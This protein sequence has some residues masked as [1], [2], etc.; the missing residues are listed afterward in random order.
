MDRAWYWKAGLIVA[1]TL[2][3]VYALVPSWTYFRLPPD[4]RNE[5][6]MFEQHRPKWA[7]ARHLNLGLDLQGG[8]HLVMDVEVARAGM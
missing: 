8:I 3:A 4:Q 6:G 5:S 7:P 1:V 2:A